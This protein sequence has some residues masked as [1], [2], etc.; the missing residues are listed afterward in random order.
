MWLGEISRGQDPAM[1][2]EQILTYH[3]QIV[4]HSLF[5]PP[6][7]PPKTKSPKQGQPPEVGIAFQING[8]RPLGWDGG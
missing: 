3:Y 2:R 5:Q 6:Y 8:H 4:G 1:A 7:Y